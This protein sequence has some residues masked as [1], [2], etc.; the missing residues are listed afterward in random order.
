M[1]VSLKVKPPVTAPFR[2]YGESIAIVFVAY[3]VLC[4]SLHGNVYF[5]SQKSLLKV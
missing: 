4:R 2:S 3:D 1:M 5:I